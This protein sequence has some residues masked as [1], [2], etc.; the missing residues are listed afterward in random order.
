MTLGSSKVH[1]L[2]LAQEVLHTSIPLTVS[3][4]L[5]WAGFP[6]VCVYIFNLVTLSC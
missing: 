5:M 1:H 3:E 2:P 6:H 4:P